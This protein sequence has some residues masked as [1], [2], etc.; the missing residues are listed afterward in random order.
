MDWHISPCRP[1]FLFVGTMFIVFG[2]GTWRLINGTLPMLNP[3]APGAV[4]I[5]EAQGLLTAA[6]IFIL[7]RAFANGGSS[8]TG[9]EAISD[10]VAL[11]KTP[12]HVNAKRTL[13]V[14]SVLLGSLVLG[15]SWFSSHIHAV[16]YESG[17][18]TVISQVAKAAVGEG[19]GEAVGEG[20]GTGV[21]AAVGEGVGE[22]VG[23][24]VGA[25][26]GEGVGEGVG[27]MV[28]AAV[29]IGVGTG[30][31]AAVGMG[32]GTG[33]GESAGVGD[34]VGAGVGGWVGAGV[35]DGVGGNF[36]G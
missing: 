26:V 21:G 33:V 15:V 3:Y 35:G 31:G 9:L 13:V 12:E 10:G 32:V 22:G 7:L 36:S 34:G 14:M 4:E 27:G 23:I 28:G 29:G 18:P 20:V 1:A 6:S 25:A 5:G 17:F 2:M 11:F 24:G 16:P 30:V 8:L 19:V